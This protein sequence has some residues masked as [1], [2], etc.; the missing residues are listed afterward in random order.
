MCNPQ[1]LRN[2]KMPVSTGTPE[3]LSLHIT[4]SVPTLPIPHTLWAYG[5]GGTARPGDP[6]ELGYILRNRTEPSTKLP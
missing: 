3:F 1:Q 6:L 2:E 4:L 5:G